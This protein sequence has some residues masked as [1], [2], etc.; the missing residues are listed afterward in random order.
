MAGV[1]VEQRG[2]KWRYRFDVS[3][4]DGKR[5]RESKGGFESKRDAMAAGVAALAKFNR[6]GAQFHPSEVSY[7][8]YLG[9][10]F[11]KY[12]KQNLKP[13]TLV[14]YQKRIRKHIVPWMGHYKLK[15]I[16]AALIQEL[17]NDLFQ[18]GYS[19]NTL[20]TIR[21]IISRSLDYAVEPMQYIEKNPT[22][23]VRL[24]SPR[25][26]PKVQTRREPHVFIPPERIEQIF[27]RFPEGTAPHI[28]MQFGYRCGMRW[29][30]AFAVKWDDV[31][32]E[33]KTLSVERQIQWNK[34][35][36]RWY[37]TEPKYNSFRKIDLDDD[38]VELLRREKARQAKAM[39]Y[40]EQKYVKLY[41]SES[42]HVNAD[43][44]GKEIAMVSVR[45]DGSLISPRVMQH[46]SAIIHKEFRYPE[47]DF[48]SFRHTHTSMLLSA[49]APL[50]YVQTRLGHKT[51]EVTLK[52]YHHITDVTIKE[53]QKA[54]KDI[55]GSAV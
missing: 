23:F 26:K 22:V 16:S 24:P 40:F 1:S 13:E 7:E 50:K 43:G 51:P 44:D 46:T 37:F 12:C 55:F 53:G 32:L 52:I 34:E 10:W 27:G 18:R 2:K 28:A 38:L 14:N 9:E 5:V 29:G 54:L 8:D 48:H 15:N 39:A 45:Q 41:E 25:V 35:A 3:T 19:R 49:G 11:E 21:G 33:A 6:A 20:S 17:I 30:E 36:Q 47:F 4:V 42:G 31:D